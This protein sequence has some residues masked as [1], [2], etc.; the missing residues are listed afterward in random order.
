MDGRT[1]TDALRL[2][3][4]CVVLLVGPGAS[5]KTTWAQAHFSPDA[6]VSSDRLRALVGFGED[7]IEASTAAFE[8]LE[9]VV[10]QRL[11]RRITTVIDTLGLDADR[12]QRWLALARRHGLPCVAVAFDTPAR[13][14]R[15]RN[16][17]RA[18]RIPADVLTA[19]LR[20]WAQTRDMLAGEGYD[21]VII[22]QPVRV[23]PEAFVGAPEAPQRQPAEPRT[24]LRFG[25]QVA[26]FDFPGKAAETAGRLSEIAGVAEAVG[27]DA[28]YV[29]D[30]FRQIPQVGRAWDDMLESYTTLGYLAAC[31]ERMR[32]GTLVT[33]ITY[34]NIAHLG[35]II[36]TLDVLSGGR[37]ICGLGIGW[38]ADEHRAY[39]WIFPAVRERYALLQDA[40]ELLPLLWGP[41]SPAYEGRVINVPEALGYPRPLQE[42]VPIMIGGSGERRTLRLAAQYADL[43]NVFGDAANVRHKAAVLRAH[44]ED[45]GRDPDQVAVTHL[46]TA[47]VGEDDRHLSEL[48]ERLRP[49]RQNPAQF[50]AS[51]NSGTVS[52]HVGR[53][54][55][56]AEAGAAEVIVRLPNLA[57]PE[58]VARI[59]KVIATFR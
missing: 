6:I 41:G 7:D 23:V 10:E 28:I 32:I 59:G 22:P 20:A 58:A 18:K 50:A 17:G 57:D 29:M 51:I 46:G 24:G 2:P 1:G 49:R 37:A 25:L 3:S 31:T 55:G 39:G 33:G 4:P 5:G 27:F 52:D 15:E 30:H 14:C 40:L 26:T 16:R 21:D 11:S 48:V 53:F 47:L 54:R 19:Q 43:S 56:L 36:A 38:F 45:L 34:R 35:K 12:R 9:T 42:H 8:L 13:E 44:C